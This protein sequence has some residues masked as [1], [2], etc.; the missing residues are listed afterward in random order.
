[1]NAVVVI[2]NGVE[3]IEGRSGSRFGPSGVGN[4]EDHLLWG[5]SPTKRPVKASPLD[6]IPEI[7]QFASARFLFLGG[8]LRGPACGRRQERWGSSLRDLMASEGYP[9][10][11]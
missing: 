6:A 7:F 4:P 1:M 8:G 2:R 11:L 9:S 5:W 10:L 3:P